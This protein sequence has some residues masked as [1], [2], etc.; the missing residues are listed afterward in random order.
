MFKSQISNLKSRTAGFTILELLI[1]ISIMAVIATLATG[2]VV[3]AIKQ[4]RQKRVEA[5][6]RALEMALVN[7]R[8]QEGKWPFKLNDL[9]RQGTEGQ[10][11]NDKKYW[12]HGEDNAKVFKE[13]YQGAGQKTV[14]LD[15]SAV[16]ALLDGQRV[17]LRAALSAG[18]RDVP[19]IYADPN[20]TSILRYYCVE[21]RVETDTVAVHAQT[22]H[23]CIKRTDK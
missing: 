21:Y 7:Y 9:D 3:K 17:Q 1:V 16:M 12:A 6:C 5:T 19:L 22:D 2:A 13:L 10:S 20:E 11:R 14:Y 23:T 4:G 18:R 8:T 15:A